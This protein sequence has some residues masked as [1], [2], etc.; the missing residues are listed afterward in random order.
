MNNKFVK[1]DTHTRFALF[2]SRFSKVLTFQFI[3]VIIKIPS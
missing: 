3:S 2:D 1:V